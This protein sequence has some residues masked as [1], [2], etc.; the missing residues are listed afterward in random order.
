[1]PVHRR[2]IT[3]YHFVGLIVALLFIVGFCLTLLYLFGEQED[4]SNHHH[5]KEN[6]LFCKQPFFDFGSMY[7][8]V[9]DTLKHSFVIKNVSDTTVKLIVKGTSCTCSGTKIEDE[10]LEAGEETNFE[11]EWKVPNA[12]GKQT[13]FAVVSDEQMDLLSLRCQVELRDC[14]A[15]D[16]EK[17]IFKK[18]KPKETLRS[19]LVVR[20]SPGEVLPKNIRIDDSDFIP[21]EFEVKIKKLTDTKMFID[22]FVTGYDSF[23]KKDYKFVINTGVPD[24]PQI[25]VPVSAYHLDNFQ[26][27]PSVVCFTREM[28]NNK[29]VFVKIISNSDNPVV[30]DNITV[31]D[32]LS[33]DIEIVSYNKNESI[34]SF[35]PICSRRE[36]S[37]KGGIARVYLKGFSRVIEIR[38]LFL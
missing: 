17:V 10:L 25:L 36:K 26:A 38:Y 3:K 6:V 35:T 9:I 19:Q 24:Q 13:L 14:L 27:I 33:V 31:D 34:L 5:G 8:P 23:G 15:L 20:A 21:K 4:N 30:V 32:P 22:V 7:R 37:S 12:L 2:I 16:R 28:Y 18:I 1:M 29:S 11:I